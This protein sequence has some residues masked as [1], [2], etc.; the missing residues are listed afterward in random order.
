MIFP[1][2]ATEEKR[3][4][5]MGISSLVCALLTVTLATPATAE[6]KEPEFQSGFGDVPQFGGPDGGAGVA[7]ESPISGGFEFK[8]RPDQAW[9]LGIGWD[10]PANRPSG[11]DDELV[12]ETSYKFQLAKN[13]SLLP[14]LQL[15]KDPANN[16]AESR[17]WV[18]GIRA[19]LTL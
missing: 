11:T 17:V 6:E 7:A 19:I 1:K 2:T 5:S 8:T 15:T 16:P 4:R 3:L 14:D 18:A 10:E 13:F 12:C 9:T